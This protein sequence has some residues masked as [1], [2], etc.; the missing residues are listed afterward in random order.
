M[1]RRHPTPALLTAAVVGTAGRAP[2]GDRA[3]VCTPASMVAAVS[4]CEW[5]QP[6]H[7]LAQG[8]QQVA[9]VQLV[10]ALRQ[11]AAFLQ[12][13]VALLAVQVPH[14][15]LVPWGHHCVS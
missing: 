4:P 11:V 7:S 14:P 13:A 9:A 12:Q 15:P 8:G 3:R 5:R 2:V 10:A 6:G 1:A